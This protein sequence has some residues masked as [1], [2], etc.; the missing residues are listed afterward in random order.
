MGETL[1]H[2]IGRGRGRGGG[3]R[4]GGRFGGQHFRG[5]LLEGLRQIFAGFRQGARVQFRPVSAAA[6]A[7]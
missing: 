1:T 4:G 5:E 3:G 2:L 7:A 6:A